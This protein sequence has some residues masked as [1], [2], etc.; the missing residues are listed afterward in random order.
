MHPRDAIDNLT[1]A[2]SIIAAAAPDAF[3][4]VFDDPR[5]SRDGMCLFGF[6][7]IERR[8]IRL[9]ISAHQ[10]DKES[11]KLQTAKDVPAQQS[12]SRLRIYNRAQV[13]RPRAQHHAH[14][15]KPQRQFIA[16][17]LRGRTQRS[18]QRKFVIARPTRKRDAIYA[19]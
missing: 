8:T 2:I 13:Q 15:R 14:Q 9:R 3:L 1:S 18:K 4:N 19:D 16:D 17:H 6:G 11:D 7:E 10:V 12:V 5:W